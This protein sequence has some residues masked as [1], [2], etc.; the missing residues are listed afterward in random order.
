MTSDGLVGG[1]GTNERLQHKA[2]NHD[3]SPARQR[4]DVHP[5]VAVVHD[6]G[7]KGSPYEGAYYGSLVAYEVSRGF[8]EAFEL[9]HTLKNS[10]PKSVRVRAC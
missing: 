5:Q 4:G 1:C 6:F 10:I 8:F 3:S 9:F 7:G 2:V